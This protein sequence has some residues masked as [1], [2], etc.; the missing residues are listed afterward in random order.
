MVKMAFELFD[1]KAG[2]IAELAHNFFIVIPFLKLTAITVVC[3]FFWDFLQAIA[4]K[5]EACIT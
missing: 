4:G 5:M 3:L 2:L 1:R